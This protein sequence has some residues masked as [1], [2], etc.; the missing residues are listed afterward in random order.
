MYILFLE[1]II[2]LYFL[3]ISIFRRVK[4]Y[5]ILEYGIIGGTLNYIRMG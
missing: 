4:F 2:N 3:I 1:I 5:F